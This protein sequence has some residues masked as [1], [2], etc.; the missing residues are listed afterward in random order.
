MLKT[1]DS[2]NGVP[3]ATFD[4]MTTGMK[5]D[6]R[7]FFTGLFKDFHGDGWITDGVSQEEKDWA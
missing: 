5:T 1:D 7:H 3:Q 6:H 4:E 2:P